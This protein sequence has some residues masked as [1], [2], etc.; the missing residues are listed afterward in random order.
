VSATDGVTELMPPDIEPYRRGNT[1]VDFV[2]T[3]E[4][5]R[6]GPHVMIMAVMHGNEAC[7]AIVLDTLFRAGVRPRRG[8]L[9]LAF[10]NIAAYQSPRAALRLVDEDMNRV[11]GTLDDPSRDSIERRRA[12]ALRPILS[13]VDYLLDLHS[14]Q[15]SDPPLMLAG[16]LP[17]GR[18]FARAVGYPEIV[19]CDAGHA[20]GVRL[21]DWGLFGDRLARPNALL[22]EAGQH[23]SA[24]SAHVAMQATL[25]FLAC[26]DTVDRK[27]LSVWPLDPTPSP[28][29]VVEVTEAV[30]ARTDG[31]RFVAD[32]SGMD[33]VPV[34]GTVIADDG[35]RPIRTPYDDCVLIMPSRRPRLGQTAV[36]LGR[37][38][39]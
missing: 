23:R 39:D 29:R 24:S 34:G 18:A 38:V 27:A 37:F 4:S 25:R 20:G 28:Q 10:G 9:T 17:K 15:S 19:V 32:Q 31:F 11:W 36:R 2:T 6:P 12:R 5:G 3:F 21:R 16:P 33:V 14:M 8:R 13:S 22:L 7:G 1:G 35:G 26:L 30:V